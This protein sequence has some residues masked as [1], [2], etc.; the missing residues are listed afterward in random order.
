MKKNSTGI[1][2]AIAC[3]ISLGALF[4]GC[5]SGNSK[6]YDTASSVSAEEE[7]H[8]DNDIAMNLR[9][10]IDAIN[11]GE[12]LDSADYNFTGILTDGS[13]RPLYTDV[14][15]TPGAWQIKVLSDNTAVISNLYLGDLLADDLV[16]YLLTSLDI[17]DEPTLIAQDDKSNAGI[18]D[19]KNEEGAGDNLSIYRTGHTDLI[20]ERQTASTPEGAE[21][22]LIKII[23]R[24][25]DF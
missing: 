11:V 10:L 22:P 18:Q 3:G 4:A 12:S 20:I 15:G 23:V 6:A 17:P 7:Y 16:Q 5:S 13:G 19:S 9:S 8:A 1:I 21:G 24:K 14:Q 2:T 25:S